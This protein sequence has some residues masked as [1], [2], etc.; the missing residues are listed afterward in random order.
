MKCTKGEIIK[1]CKDYT[2]QSVAVSLV[3]SVWNKTL[4][5]LEFIK[6]NF[7][8]LTSN[9]LDYSIIEIAP[10]YFFKN[11]VWFQSPV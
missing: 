2:K 1:C 6:L 5:L 7:K 9:Y 4:K 3:R 10:P 8:F 11:K